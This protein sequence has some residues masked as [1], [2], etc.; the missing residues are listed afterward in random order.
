[1]GRHSFHT[2]SWYDFRPNV[3][4]RAQLRAQVFFVCDEWWIGCDLIVFDFI[5]REESAQSQDVCVECM[6]DILKDLQNDGTA[7]E[8]LIYML[9]VLHCTNLLSN[10]N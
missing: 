10:L 4:R 2:S 9:K 1:M 5:C 6:V 7:G 3:I 8:F